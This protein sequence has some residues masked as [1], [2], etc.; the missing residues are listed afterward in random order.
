MFDSKDREVEAAWLAHEP[1]RAAISNEI[2]RSLRAWKR[3]L[4]PTAGIIEGVLKR[5][6]LAQSLF[7]P[8]VRKRGVGRQRKLVDLRKMLPGANVKISFKDI[9]EISWLSPKQAILA[10]PQHQGEQHDCTLVCFVAAFSPTPHSVT[11][12]SAWAAEIPDHA[13]ARILQRAPKSDLRNALFAAGLAFLA[14][15]AETVVPLV[16]QD[17]SIYLP[18]GP[19]AFGGKV[20]GAR[21]VDGRSSYVYART[22]TWLSETMLR[23]DQTL[24]PPAA[25][26]ERTVALAL[27][28]WGEAGMVRPSLQSRAT[29][30]LQREGQA[31]A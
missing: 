23:A 30:T 6:E 16:G 27:W 31:P 10:D 18:A 20:I 19:G 26:A 9:L 15:D 7:E 29:Q 12:H 2:W 28:Q 3:E 24:L 5:E 1:E 21:T 13:A 22:N 4:L 8:C 25:S 11:C 14:A 17:T